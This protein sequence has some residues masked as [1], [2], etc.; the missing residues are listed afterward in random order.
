[1]EGARGD[2]QDVLGLHPPCWSSLAGAVP[3]DIADRKVSG[4]R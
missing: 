1:V 2:E 4:H 3:E